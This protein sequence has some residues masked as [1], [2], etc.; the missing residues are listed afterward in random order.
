MILRQ[1]ERPKEVVALRVAL[2][3]AKGWKGTSK[4]PEAIRTLKE[5]ASKSHAE[6]R[7]MEE[8]LKFLNGIEAEALDALSQGHRALEEG[9]FK[10]GA[11]VLE[12]LASH[13]EGTHSGAAAQAE[14]KVLRQSRRFQQEKQAA[15]MLETAK[16]HQQKRE[17][18]KCREAL[19]SILRSLPDTEAA[20]EAR[21]LLESLPA[22]S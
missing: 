9:Y 11:E 17:N 5:L 12:T 7:L 6:P 4:M 1:V 2:D 21:S 10:R 20:K 18:A 22:K 3:R 14:L 13:Y 16:E 8:A 19:E 15:K